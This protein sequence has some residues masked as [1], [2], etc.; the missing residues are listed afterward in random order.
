MYS[1]FAELIKKIKK[2]FGNH[3]GISAHLWNYTPN[4]MVGIKGGEH[5]CRLLMSDSAASTRT[6]G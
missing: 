5:K 4:S 6:V 1:G 3:E 2:K